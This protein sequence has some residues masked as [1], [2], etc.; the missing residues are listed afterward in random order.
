MSGEYS[1]ST[2]TLIEFSYLLIILLLLLSLLAS[3]ILVLK[4]RNRP[5][6]MAA[7]PFGI[8]C[9]NYLLLSVNAYILDPILSRLFDTE[10]RIYINISIFCSSY[11]ITIVALILYFIAFWKLLKKISK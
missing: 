3:I 10:S 8:L 1:I 7:L 9:I 11:I 2:S 5:A 4:F 6:T